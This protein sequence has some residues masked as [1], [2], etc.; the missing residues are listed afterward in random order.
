MQNYFLIDCR[1]ESPHDADILKI[2][3]GKNDASNLSA[4]LQIAEDSDVFCE[5]N[6][7]NSL[8]FVSNMM[9]E[10]PGRNFYSVTAA[11]A[12]AILE[13]KTTA[14]AANAKNLSV[15]YRR[16]EKFWSDH[17]PSNNRKP[18]NPIKL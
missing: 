13:N 11:T 1:R 16:N 3:I 9:A 5:L 14:N 4:I 6:A 17:Q 8:R 15:N 12:R 2:R 18:F 7:P 10:N